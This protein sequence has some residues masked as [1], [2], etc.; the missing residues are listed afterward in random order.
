MNPPVY[1]KR[2]RLRTDGK[3]TTLTVKHIIDS[4]AIDGMKE[5][6][7]IVDDFDTTNDLLNQM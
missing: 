6:E 7:V 1:E 2:I 5:R 3:K 4:Q